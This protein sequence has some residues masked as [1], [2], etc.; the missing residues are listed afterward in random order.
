MTENDIVRACLDIFQTFKVMAWRN[1]TGSM[2]KTYKGK[3]HF[4][5]FGEPGSPDI[6]AVYGGQ[7]IGVECKKPGGKQSPSQK[8]FQAKL[9][10]AG[11]TYLL[12]DNPDI[13]ISYLKDLV[14]LI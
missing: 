12:V 2:T 6:I 1:N 10:D 8:E 14:C 9:E 7:F 4:V 5:R 11:G 3:T 13:L